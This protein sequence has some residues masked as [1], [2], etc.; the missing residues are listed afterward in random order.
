MRFVSLAAYELGLAID[1]AFKH[2]TNHLCK[3]DVLALAI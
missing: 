2:D 3:L 1:K